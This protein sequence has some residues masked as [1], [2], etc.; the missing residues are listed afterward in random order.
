MNS[1][2]LSFG[3]DGLLALLVSLLPA[4]LKK[5]PPYQA[6]ATPGWHVVSGIGETAAGA[7]LFFWG[8]MRYVQGFLMGPGWLYCTAPPT[9]AGSGAR[10]LAAPGLIGYLSFLLTP[11]AWICLYAMVE[12]TLRALEAVY[13]GTMPGVGPV[14]LVINLGCRLWAKKTER[15]LE[16]RVGPKRPDQLKRLLGRG[17]EVVSRN[18]YPWE[19]GRV[20]E[21]EGELYVVSRV[22]RV[23]DGR[24]L[25]FRHVL[26]LL[27][28]GEV[29]RGEVI[30]Y[31]GNGE[32]SRF[33]GRKS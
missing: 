29:I 20:V 23:L 5:R 12:G 3:L 16:R 24:W 19:E 21:L 1:A 17:L 33:P 25:A 31:A 30:R 28:P 26:R 13:H 22:E 7:L 8:F 10:Y 14:V 15:S 6:Y 11:F 2:A 27:E 32:P 9:V 18:R 4:D